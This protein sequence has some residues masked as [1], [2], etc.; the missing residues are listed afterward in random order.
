[1]KWRPR[2]NEQIDKN[3]GLNKRLAESSAQDV[4]T[5]VSSGLAETQKEKLASLAESV[6]FESE[7]EYREKAGNSEGV[8]LLQNSFLLQRP[9]LLKLSL[10]V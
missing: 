6:E 5:Q 10:R 3:I 1:M 8:V 2:L 7:E 9:N 4:L